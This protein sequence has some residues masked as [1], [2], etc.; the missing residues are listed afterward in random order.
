MKMKWM[1]ILWC[2]VAFTISASASDFDTFVT[3]LNSNWVAKNYVGIRETIT[4]R[5]NAISNDLPALVAK[6]DYYTVI[7]LNM[8]EVSNSISSIRAVT[9]DLQWENGGMEDIILEA[10]LDTI[11][12]R[13]ESELAGYIF[14]LSPE[15][16][17]QLH[18]ES[19]ANYPITMI[20]PD[21]AIIQYGTD[22]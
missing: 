17:E 10:M 7:E 13:E 16:L 9:N 18:Q 19:P 22:D 4:N 6:M 20:L 2:M 15:Q 5:L 1:K 21:Y 12:N 8:N 14:G 3:S 11:E